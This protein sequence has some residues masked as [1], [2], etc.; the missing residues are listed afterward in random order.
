MKLESRIYLYH[1]A[2]EYSMREA[3]LAIKKSLSRESGNDVKMERLNG[4]EITPLKLIETC[5]ATDL[6]SSQRLVIVD[7]LLSHLNRRE[8]KTGEKKKKTNE[9]DSFSKLTSYI[10]ENLPPPVTIIFT[11]KDSRKEKNPFFTRLSSI[12]RTTQFSPLKG[13]D[14]RKWIIDKV[15][16]R[17]C[18]ISSAATALLAN[19]VGGNLLAL[20][21]EIEKLTLYAGGKI[22]EEADVKNVTSLARQATIFALVDSIIERNKARSQQYLHQLL[23]EG[24]EPTHVVAML[25]RQLSFL[26]RTRD[27]LDK[28]KPLVEIQKII[29]LGG[30]QW[31][32]VVI[33]ARGCPMERLKKFYETLLSYDMSMKKGQLP[34]ELALELLVA[35]LWF[36]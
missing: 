36:V 18:K 16:E 34:K 33:Q 1:G 35:E 22:I 9:A 21:Q 8:E 17:G 28:K 14:L 23:A 19:L 25:N 24:E 2:D 5:A 20:S 11:E 31:D 6:F 30:F 27:L 3:I 15:K 12:A 13:D 10:K 7:G 32:R 4:E 26:V 29:G